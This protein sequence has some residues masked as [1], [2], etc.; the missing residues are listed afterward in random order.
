M[1]A[2]ARV[3]GPDLVGHGHVPRLTV[4]MVMVRTGIDVTTHTK[5]A[6]LDA[7]WRTTG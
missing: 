5:A 2:F 6:V 3:R 1:K 4:T 7:E